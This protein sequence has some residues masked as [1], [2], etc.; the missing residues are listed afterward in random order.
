M[1]GMGSRLTVDL[2]GAGVSGDIRHPISIV[3]SLGI[4]YERTAE[5][6]V[7]EACVFYG[8]TNVPIRLPSYIKQMR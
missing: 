8:C 3:R 1:A 7:L 4:D 6:L 2:Y 5:H